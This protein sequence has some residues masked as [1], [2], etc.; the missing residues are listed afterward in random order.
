[1]YI[2]SINFSERKST[3]I[4]AK[5]FSSRTLSSALWLKCTLIKSASSLTMGR[6][7]FLDSLSKNNSLSE[8]I[9]SR[10]M[11]SRS[12]SRLGEDDGVQ[13]GSWDSAAGRLPTHDAT[14]RGNHNFF[15]FEIWI[16]NSSIFKKLLSPASHLGLSLSWSLVL[17]SQMHSFLNFPVCYKKFFSEYKM[18]ISTVRHIKL[19]QW[20]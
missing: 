10:T 4:S 12:S 14:E 2:G 18:L 20:N 19:F 16:R 8:E 15:N 1:M 7:P 5:L 17:W 6:I 9:L 13:C 11:R 3:K